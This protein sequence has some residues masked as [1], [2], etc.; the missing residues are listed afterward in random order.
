MDGG[1]FHWGVLQARTGVA[2]WVLIGQ[3]WRVE[4]GWV[5]LNKLKGEH[6]WVSYMPLAAVP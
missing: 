3:G 6:N 4:M 2:H 1:D 5:Q